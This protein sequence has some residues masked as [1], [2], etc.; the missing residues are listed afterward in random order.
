MKMETKAKLDKFN[1]LKLHRVLKNLGKDVIKIPAQLKQLEG[2]SETKQQEEYMRVCSVKLPM[3]VFYGVHSLK[4]T[5]L[6]KLC[7]HHTLS[8]QPQKRH[9][10]QLVCTE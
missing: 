6:I 3:Y 8:K 10:K 1:D 2:S 5:F 7:S 4:S 9:P